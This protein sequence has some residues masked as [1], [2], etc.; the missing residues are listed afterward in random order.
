MYRLPGVTHAE[1]PNSLNP[2]RRKSWDCN[3]RGSEHLY[4]L[5]VREFP[6]DSRDVITDEKAS[7][8]LSSLIQKDT[9]NGIHGVGYIRSGIH[10]GDSDLHFFDVRKLGNSETRKL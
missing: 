7:A 1:L 4:T 10:E 9:R 5:L 8:E 2:C 6:G 3:N